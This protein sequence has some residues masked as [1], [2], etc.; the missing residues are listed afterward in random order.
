M[1]ESGDNTDKYMKQVEDLVI[2]YQA[3]IIAYLFSRANNREVAYDLAQETFLV[4]LKRI[5]DFDTSRPA[6]PWL[7]GIAHNLL[8]EYWRTK[9]NESISDSLEIFLAQHQIENEKKTNALEYLEEQ[10]EAL[11]KC[12]EKLPKKG[13]DLVK[14][15]YE[16]KLKC[17]EVAQR[18]NTP[19]STIR[20]TI[21]RIRVGLRACIKSKVRMKAV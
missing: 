7:V 5:E 17:S 19:A 14:L 18:L 11:R 6:W 21:H 4:V 15:V 10:T 13:R 9:K 1:L 2:T 3:R 8:H 16:E 20:T 12:L